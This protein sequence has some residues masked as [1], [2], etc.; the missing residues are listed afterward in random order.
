M[1]LS[2]FKDGDTV[3]CIKS[4][5]DCAYGAGAI[6]EGAVC[7]I[8]RAECQNFYGV[9]TIIESFNEKENHNDIYYISVTKANRCFKLK[10][11]DD[12]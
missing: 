10:S 1:K 11:K 4:C 3:V 8:K 9:Y 6:R 12:N 2:H 7:Y 5:K